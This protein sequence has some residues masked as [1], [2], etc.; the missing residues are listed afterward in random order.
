M[1]DE[2]SRLKDDNDKYTRELGMKGERIKKLELTCNELVE[3]KTFLEMK[4]KNVDFIQRQDEALK[5]RLS[6]IYAGAIAGGKT[7]TRADDPFAKSSSPPQFFKPTETEVVADK[8]NVI[9]EGGSEGQSLAE[10]M[11]ID[12]SGMAV[13]AS[14]EKVLKPESGAAKDAG[15]DED[16]NMLSLKDIAP[17]V[18]QAEEKKESSKDFVPEPAEKKPAAPGQEKVRIRDSNIFQTRGYFKNRMGLE[19]ITEGEEAAG[20]KSSVA[21]AKPAEENSLEQNKAPDVAAPEGK[22]SELAEEGKEKPVEAGATMGEAKDLTLEKQGVVAAAVS[23]GAMETKGAAEEHKTENAQ[24]EEKKLQEKMLVPSA[25]EDKKE[26][27]AKKE[28]KKEFA[29]NMASAKTEGE[30][31]EGQIQTQSQPLESPMTVPTAEEKTKTSPQK[32]APTLP[33]STAPIASPFSESAASAKEKLADS[34]KK[35]D[36]M[37]AKEAKELTREGAAEKSPSGR[38]PIVF[39]AISSH[40]RTRRRRRRRGRCTRSLPIR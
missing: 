36:G 35:E 33:S 30:E 20:K 28:E 5:P 27:A 34:P 3:E 11:G 40:D 29:T 2:N 1:A 31:K 23:E 22:K 21:P 14:I 37:A 16:D 26:D 39:S 32:E 8:P 15:Q 17:D 19:T 9:A 6:T 13:R 25:S 18:A 12:K 4:M 38:V 24:A 10:Q 7:G